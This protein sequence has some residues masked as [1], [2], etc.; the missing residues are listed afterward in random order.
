MSRR[1]TDP[2][3]VGSRDVGSLD[4]GS[5]DGGS[6]DG[7]SLDVGLDHERLLFAR[8]QEMDSDIV[9]SSR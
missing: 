3:D 8:G 4:G 2:V 1:S 7:G 6:L 9:D 5:L